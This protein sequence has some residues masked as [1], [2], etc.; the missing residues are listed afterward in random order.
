MSKKMKK[1]ALLIS[2][3]EFIALWDFWKSRDAKQPINCSICGS[4]SSNTR[5]FTDCS[6]HPTCFEC[7]THAFE[8]DIKSC[9]LCP[10]KPSDAELWCNTCN[11]ISNIK[12][13]SASWACTHCETWKQE[14]SFLRYYRRNKKITNFLFPDE[15]HQFLH[16]NNWDIL[17]CP[18]CNIALERESACHEM[19]HC[20]RQSCCASCGAFSF[21]WETGLTTHQSETKCSKHIDTDILAQMWGEREALGIRFKELVLNTFIVDLKNDV[22]SQ[23]L[24]VA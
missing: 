18:G 9:P 4:S 17:K 6:M 15:L 14:P 24:P 7:W 3:E 12:V 10:V 8:S 11:K 22:T 16:I 2:D 1:E 23:V 13:K 20:G 21:S 5:H 19:H